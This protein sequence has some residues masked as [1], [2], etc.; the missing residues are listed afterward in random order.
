MQG[1]ACVVY[2]RFLCAIKYGQFQHSLI[3][4][5]STPDR[6]MR[7]EK[8]SSHK[9]MC[10]RGGGCRLDVDLSRVAEGHE[11]SVPDRLL[12]FA[13]LWGEEK[14][15]IISGRIEAGSRPSSTMPVTSLS[16]LR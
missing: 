10:K 1:P 2:G 14:A 16:P 15:T 12:E 7:V 6:P 11:F 3:A 9:Q 13:I 4:Q 8:S 5:L